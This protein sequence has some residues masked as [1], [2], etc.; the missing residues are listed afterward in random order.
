MSAQA[1]SRPA[2]NEYAAYYDRY[3]SLVPEGDIVGVIEKQKDETLSLLRGISEDRAGHRYA[4]DKW[5]IKEV[6]GH[7]IDAERVFAYRALR[8]GRG[9]STELAGFEQDDYVKTGGFDGRTLAD[10]ACEFEHVR[11]STIS[12]LRNLDTV[13]LARTGVAS[14]NLVSVKAL[15]YIIAGHELHHMSVLRERYLN[16]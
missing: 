10:L 4:A 2:R 12:L 9:D 14:E 6:V 15:V 13:A 7:V 5:S 11:D 3:I 16:S 1:T 8:F